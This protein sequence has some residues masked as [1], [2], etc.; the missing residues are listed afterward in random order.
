ME[1]GDKDEKEDSMSKGDENSEFSNSLDDSQRQENEEKSNKQMIIA[2]ILN[3]EYEVIREVMKEAMNWKLSREPEDETAS[4]TKDWDIYWHDLFINPDMLSKMKCYQKVNHFPGMEALYMKNLLSRNLTRMYKLYPKEYSFF[5]VTWTLPIEWNEFKSQFDGVSDKTFIVKPEAL[6]QGKGIFLTKTWTEINPEANCIVQ[7]YISHPYLID[8]LKFDLRIYVLVY[9]CDPYRVYMYKE[10]LA[11]LATEQYVAPKINNIRNVYMHLTNY[12]INKDNENYEYNTD[13]DRADTG[14]KRSL[15]FV[16]EYIEENGGDTEQVKEDI[17]VCIMKSLCSVQPYL[18]HLYRSCQPNDIYNDKCFE[19]LGFDIL[20]DH[21]LKPWL[22]EVNHA[23]SFRTDTPFDYK[24][25]S[26]MLED[27]FRILNLDPIKRNLRIK[28]ENDLQQKRIMMDQNSIIKLSREERMRRKAKKMTKRDA[29]ES[30]NLGNFEALYPDPTR[31]ELYKLYMKSAA[32]IW[33]TFTGTRKKLAV[34]EQ[35]TPD[36]KYKSN[37]IITKVPLSSTKKKSIVKE[38]SFIYRDHDNE[39]P[40]A[41]L[42]PLKQTFQADSTQ[43]MLITSIKNGYKLRPI[44][45]NK[46]ETIVQQRTKTEYRNRENNFRR[47]DK[48]GITRSKTGLVSHRNDNKE[49][50]PPTIHKHNTPSQICGKGLYVV[51]KMLEF[52]PFDII[53]PTRIP[54]IYR[55]K[56]NPYRVYKPKIRAYKPYA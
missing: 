44:E 35:V 21:K 1:K 40:N 43:G 55:K 26:A 33:E 15:E 34:K 38:K 11:R 22:L 14:H 23:P 27:T 42:A 36:N 37:L 17:K 50:L 4:T 19:I 52:S 10:G 31:D 2:N 28:K 8:G 6:S 29:Y 48:S 51:P 53:A 20:L 49:I 30:K 56:W 18:A 9:G 3:A 7:R 39:K 46:V 16:W 13:A 24:I 5:P 41:Y 47:S 32:D 54:A 12:A 45:C 25:K